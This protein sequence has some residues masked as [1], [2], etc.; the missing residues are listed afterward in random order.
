MA[1]S[2]SNISK[3]VLSVLSVFV[4]ARSHLKVLV[5]PSRCAISLSTS[6]RFWD[7]ITKGALQGG[8]ELMDGFSKPDKLAKIVF[9]RSTGPKGGEQDLGVV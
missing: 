5:R 1:S 7:T 3:P 8:G 6:F 2:S 4:V 9:A